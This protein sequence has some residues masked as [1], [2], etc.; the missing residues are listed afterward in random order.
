MI[1]YND[2]CYISDKTTGIYIHKIISKI[3]VYR[4]SWGAFIFSTKG[5]S[6]SL[7]AELKENKFSWQ[8]LGSEVGKSTCFQQGAPPPL[9]SASCS[10]AQDLS[11]SV[12][13]ENEPSSV[14]G[15][16]GEA[17]TWLW[18]GDGE[19]AGLLLLLQSFK[20]SPIFRS[21]FWDTWSL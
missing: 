16:L 15:G 18:R 3:I 5:S 8:C 13:L 10:R 9:L 1:R 19:L 4:A 2:L 14:H 6:N 17:I 7:S 21:V 11:A 20:W 12:S